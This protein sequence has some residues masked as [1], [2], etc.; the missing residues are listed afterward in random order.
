MHDLRANSPEVL[1]K[2]GDDMKKQLDEVNVIRPITILLLVIM[3]SFTM[4]AGGWSLPEGIEKIRAYFWIQKVT[5][6]SMLE[7]FVFISGY[8][9]AYQIY[10]QKKQLAFKTLVYSKFKRLIIPSL[11][12][13][14][15]YALFFYAKKFTIISFSYDVLSGIGHMWFLPMLFW[16]FIATY[17]LLKLNIKD[18]FKLMFLFCVSIVSI[19]PLPFRMTNTMYYLFFFYLAFYVWNHRVVILDRFVNLKTVICSFLLFVILFVPLT[20]VREQIYLQINDTNEIIFKAV[21]LCFGKLLQ[22]IYAT[23]GLLSFYITV[24]YF[25]KFI[26]IPQWLVNLNALCMGVYI[27]HQFILQYL[28]YYTDV[29]QYLGSYWLPWF[30]L[31]FSLFSSLLLA[32][33]IRKTSVGRKLL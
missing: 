23:V 27:I 6:S 22:I 33:L 24:L 31:F 3:H 30:G 12:F 15:L 25:L 1:L 28:Y 21:Y 2:K 8:I 26:R 13:S 10:E 32:W 7:M 17:F 20:L 9:F 18:E 19:I 5:F 4:Y 29:P 14:L 11:I 16:C